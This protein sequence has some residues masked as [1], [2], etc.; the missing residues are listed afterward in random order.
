MQVGGIASIYR[1]EK[2]CQAASGRA[3]QDREV[4]LRECPNKAKFQRI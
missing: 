3:E 1:Q 4:V 2:P